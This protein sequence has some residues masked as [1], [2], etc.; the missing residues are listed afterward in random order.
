MLY[1][2]E[3]FQKLRNKETDIINGKHKEV[4]AIMTTIH[5]KRIHR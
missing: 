3:F 1:S 2:I 4:I 5:A